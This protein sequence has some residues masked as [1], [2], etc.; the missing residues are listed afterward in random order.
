ML[1][2]YIF[3][4]GGLTMRKTKVQRELAVKRYLSGESATAITT[5][6]G[7]SR[8]ALYLWIKQFSEAQNEKGNF[9]SVV[10]YKRLQ[11]KVKRLEEI[12]KIYKTVN[13][14]YNS[15][16]KEK[17]YALEELYGQHSVHILCEALD[18]SRGT[19]YNHILRNKKQNTVYVQR[20]EELREKIQK[21]YDDINQI[22]GAGKIMAVLKEQ[23]VKAGE[24]TIR[25]LMRDMGIKSIRQEAKSLYDKEKKRNRNLLQQ[26]FNPLRPNQVWVSDIT[27]FRLKEKNFYICVILDLYSRAVVGYKIGIKNSTQLTKSTFKLAYINRQLQSGLMFHSDNGGNYCCKTFQ[28]YLLKLNVEQS[29][30]RPYVPYD[31]SVMES[32]FASMKREE[33]YRR[34]F[35]S[36]NEFY[37]SV[38][39]YIIFYNGKRPHYQ[40][41]YRTPLKKE[42]DYYKSIE[43]K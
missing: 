8:S 7:I 33:L 14:H 21:I 27:M 35:K 43:Q 11:G 22:F 29:F 36:E 16:L 9:I 24:K 2:G 19:F 39:D 5:E 15:P 30:S 13:C 10:S 25:L 18:V 32:F 6:M 40:N 17:L 23:G 41:S 1:L 28:T 12:I 3:I 37:K 20:K 31:N 42:Q 38:A 26:Q 4:F 34:K